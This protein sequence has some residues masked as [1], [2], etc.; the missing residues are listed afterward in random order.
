MYDACNTLGEGSSEF[1]FPGDGTH[2]VCIKCVYKYFVFIIMV[3]HREFIIMNY[4][5][6]IYMYIYMYI[7]VYIY[8]YIYI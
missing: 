5:L 2:K 7:Y 3:M 4:Y 1:S 8:I 6:S